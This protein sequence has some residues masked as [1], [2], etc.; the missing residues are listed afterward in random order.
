M[1]IRDFGSV[2]QVVEGDKTYMEGRRIGEKWLLYCQQ[3]RADG[4]EPS[5]RQEAQSV[6]L[7]HSHICAQDAGKILTKA[8][9]PL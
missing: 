8:P 9:K 2:F 5:D 7:R 4:G 1:R 3:C 6:A